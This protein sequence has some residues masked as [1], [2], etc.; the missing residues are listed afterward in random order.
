M[1]LDS[2]RRQAHRAASHQ[3]GN[4]NYN[5]FSRVL[6]RDA[7]TD[8]ESQ[9]H[10][11]R[12]EAFVT[13][14]L[15]QQRHLETSAAGKDYGPPLHH[16]TEPSNPSPTTALGSSSVPESSK[17][18]DIVSHPDGEKISSEDGT[19]VGSS[20][21][22]STGLT[23]R[24]KFK[25]LLRKENE[26]NDEEE[27]QRVE[28]EQLSMEERKRKAHKRKIPVGAWINVLLLMVPVGFVVNYLH[29]GDIPVFVINFFAIIPLAAM[30]STATEELAL[31]VG[32]T[33]GGL[34]NATFGYVGHCPS[35]TLKITD[36]N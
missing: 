27:L 24:A 21:E 36:T 5:P 28:S 18:K 10:R 26:N 20:R 30:L 16:N 25:T 7:Y 31:R 34:L 22:N 13:P 17:E 2:V 29:I 35:V 19:V 23:K 3:S 32:E 15:E 4:Q 14:D 9:P 11:S 6:S 33:M 12:S 1:F 8:E